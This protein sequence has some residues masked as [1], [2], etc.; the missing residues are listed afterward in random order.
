MRYFD[1]IFSSIY[2]FFE[3]ID[4]N[5]SGNKGTSL[6]GAIFALTMLLTANTLSFFSEKTV[7]EIRWLY[8]LSVFVI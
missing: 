3:A 6:I 1:N 7:T 8:F 4:D 5:R 2:L